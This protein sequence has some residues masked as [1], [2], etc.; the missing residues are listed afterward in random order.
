MGVSV[1]TWTVSDEIGHHESH[2][3]DC[4][5]SWLPMGHWLRH[6]TAPPPL[7]L[8]SQ[9]MENDALE[10]ERL[11]NA[12]LEA[13]EIALRKDWSNVHPNTEPHQAKP[14][15]NV[16]VNVEVQGLAAF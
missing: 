15:G 12:G 9:Q 6:D 5:K 1:L 16:I 11:S 13:Q 7:P 10:Y 4:Y 8:D 14:K 2:D 3:W